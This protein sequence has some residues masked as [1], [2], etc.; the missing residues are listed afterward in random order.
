MA[1]GS[2]C[3]ALAAALLF[4][5]CGGG[6]TSAPPPAFTLSVAPASLRLPPALKATVTVIVQADPG[7]SGAVDLEAQGLGGDL[8]AAFSPGRVE[9]PAGGSVQALLTLQA[10]ET[11]LP[12]Q[13]VVSVLGRGA[14][15]LATADLRLDIPAARIFPV[16]T[17]L[18]QGQANLTFLAYQDGDGPWTGIEGQGGLYKLPVTDPGGRFGIFYGATCTVGDWTSWAANG[19]YQSLADTQALYVAFLCNLE[20]G[21]PAKTFDL[22]GLLRNTGG[23][24]GLISANSGL[25][26]FDP[27]APRYDLKLYRGPGDLVAAT[28]PDLGTYLPS[29]FIVERGRDTQESG[30]R[31]LDFALEGLDPGPRHPVSLPPLEPGEALLG[32]VQYQT[33]GGQAVILASGA[34]PTEYAEFPPSAARAG[35]AYVYGLQASS[36]GAI[37]TVVGSRTTVPGALDLRLPT[38]IAPFQV[39]VE[40]G[41]RKR[42]GLAWAPISPVPESH[43]ATFLQRTAQEEAYW[44]VSLSRRWLGERTAFTWMPPDLT[45]FPG[46]DARF[47]FRPG[48]GVQVVL[49]QSGLQAVEEAVVPRGLGAPFA[50]R[51][52]GPEAGHRPGLPRF[53]VRRVPGEAASASPEYV[54]ATRL[55]SLT[56]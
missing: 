38:G 50:A 27:G 49:G 36:P 37:R 6:G 8:E 39:P 9:V 21:P 25:W 26:A 30:S 5:G 40:G 18:N 31:D 43:Q 4:L 20:P 1:G 55:Q 7:F 3:L 42:L 13:R 11:A 32:T 22:G 17:F 46:F 53:Q 33:S 29:R 56:P 23:V 15:A 47:L 24:G 16:T 48:V 54:W 41:A 14:T 2:R 52:G 51:P 28:Y 35:D 34:A 45:G 19:F 12:A 10:S 44:F